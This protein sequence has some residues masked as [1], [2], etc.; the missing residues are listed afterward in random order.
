M[1]NRSTVL[2]ITIFYDLEEKNGR[3]CNVY[4]TKLSTFAPQ[5]TNCK[6]VL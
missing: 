1:K 2:N 4:I 6:D 5:I 3:I